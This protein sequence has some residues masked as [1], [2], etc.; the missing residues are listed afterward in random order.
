MRAF[1]ILIVALAYSLVAIACDEGAGPSN[2]V[3]PSSPDARF[4]HG[5]L[6]SGPVSFSVS[7]S[8]DIPE[9]AEVVG[10]TRHHYFAVDGHGS[11]HVGIEN[12]GPDATHHER[13][14]FQ[15][16]SP[17][18]EFQEMFEPHSPD[19]FVD[20]ANPDPDPEVEPAWECDIST[21]DPPGSEQSTSGT[22]IE[23]HFDVPAGF[24]GLSTVHTVSHRTASVTIHLHFVAAPPE[25]VVR[26]ALILYARRDLGPFQDTRA[27]L[28]SILES[29]YDVV[30]EHAVGGSTPQQVE[31]RIRATFQDADS[32]D[33]SL[34]Y[35]ISHG[36]KSQEAGVEG[37]ESADED[38]FKPC[39]NFK[40]NGE[41]RKRQVP[42]DEGIIP[43][44]SVN[45]ISDDALS[46]LFGPFEI[47]GEDRF[48]GPKILMFE[49]C[50][51]GGFV[52]GASDLSLPNS[53]VMMAANANQKAW[54]NAT[55][56]DPA[57]DA[58][59][60]HGFFGGSIVAG[61]AA[62]EHR[63]GKARADSDGDDR[64]TVRELFAYVQP[65]V[66]AVADAFGIRRGQTPALWPGA[67]S[68]A[69]KEPEETS[70]QWD[71]PV[72]EYEAADL[73]THPQDFVM[74]TKG[75][76]GP[77]PNQGGCE[78]RGPECTV[79]QR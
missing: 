24:V 53:V 58:A 6:G 72:L 14:T 32:D 63:P 10:G 18:A 29:G 42:C 74:V 55:A 36:F 34:V 44:D 48:D 78:C 4:S 22:S 33:V 13:V 75:V 8:G 79:E 69:T 30:E 77:I 64:V 40:K 57:A 62:D 71:L 56:F 68:D 28:R 5:E 11:V 25:E 1:P 7:V 66:I 20:C 73:I 2:P 46:E 39:R 54:A 47:G 9:L 45:R 15:V 21:L 3:S 35:W 52:D 70:A 12:Q 67:W 38:N 37:D 76:R 23:Y 60:R 51:A 16:P 61:L 19:S 31:D 43:D 41:P 59:P 17:L 50:F 49:T 65:K 26:R 27:D